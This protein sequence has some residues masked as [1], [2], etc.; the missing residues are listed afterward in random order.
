MKNNEQL[1]ERKRQMNAT[2]ITFGIEIECTIPVQNAP[3]VGGY[4]NGVQIAGLPAGWNAQRDSSIQAQRGFVGV[5]VVSPVL[6]GVD[7]TRQIKLVCE[8]LK[9]IGAKV[10]RST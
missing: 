8:W 1:N 6:K 7:G 3:A 2:E 9:Q 5:E 10:N 4:H